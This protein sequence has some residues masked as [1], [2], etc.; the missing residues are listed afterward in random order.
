MSSCLMSNRNLLQR[1]G[2]LAVITGL[3]I[4]VSPGG[5]IAETV[6]SNAKG[7]IAV[8]EFAIRGEHLDPQTGAIIADSLTSAIANIGYFALKDRMSLSAIAKLARKNPLGSIGPVDAE[9]AIQLGTL[10]G[11]D[12][13]ITGT[14]SRLGDRVIVTARLIDTRSGTVL[15]SGEIQ[16]KDLDAVQVKLDQLALSITTTPPA[17]SL[18]ALTIKTE[19]DGAAIKLLNLNQIYQPGIR[20]PSGVYEIEVSHS[21]YVPQKV[22]A[23]ILQND[24]NLLIH[25]EKNRYALT[26][27]VE[28]PQAKIRI[29][30]LQQPY[31]PGI[32]LETGVYQLE[33][34]CPGYQNTRKT[35]TIADADLNVVLK[36]E[37][38]NP[39]S[40]TPVKPVPARQT[41][42]KNRP[43]RQSR[44]SANRDETQ[45]NPPDREEGS[46]R[47]E[48]RNFR[49]ELKKL[50]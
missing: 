44:A 33:I 37:P 36:L 28:P 14:I 43:N 41:A 49:H 35:L 10:Y 11:I 32:K 12:G 15:R 31:Q 6:R 20:L 26:I 50:W 29:L 3:L 25:L 8:V 22:N 38:Q 48:F 30:N 45:W 24:V 17:Q 13:V 40:T 47:R 9:T 23:K 2:V 34:T 18:R 5:L 16:E 19:P 39:V 7:T 46:F 21:G 42:A 4:A 1:L 27:D